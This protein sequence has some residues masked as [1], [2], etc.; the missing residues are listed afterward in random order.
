MLSL[1]AAVAVHVNTHRVAYFRD[2]RCQEPARVW[3]S[4]YEPG[5]KKRFP[6]PLGDSIVACAAYGHAT[7][8]GLDVRG[9]VVANATALDVRP[10]NCNALAVG[11]VRVSCGCDHEVMEEVA[12]GRCTVDACDHHV[13]ERTCE[14]LCHRLLNRT[15]ADCTRR[16]SAGC[17]GRS[18]HACRV[19]NASEE[20]AVLL[21]ECAEGGGR[22]AERVPMTDLASGDL[23]LDADLATRVLVTQHRRVLHAARVIRLHFDDGSWLVVTPDHALLLDDA[24]VSAQKARVGSVATHGAVLVATSIDYATVVNPLTDSG[25]I[26]AYANATSPPVRVPVYPMWIAEQMLARGTSSIFRSLARAFPTTVQDFYDTVV[27]TV[28]PAQL[29]SRRRWLHALMRVPVVGVV[30]VDVTIAASLLVYAAYS[31]AVTLLVC[32]ATVLLLR[33]AACQCAD[34]KAGCEGRDERQCSRIGRPAPPVPDD[35]EKHKEKL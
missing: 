10:R 18:T 26:L 17:F 29:P 7:L 25:T 15:D 9:D 23:V 32:V 24:V 28:M 34:A 4:E 8:H 33:R 14:P 35:S 16:T 27:E 21:R 19:R 5:E 30:V 20:H 3:V 22:N 12:H 11:A 31:Q 13:A 6:A 2:D 1:G